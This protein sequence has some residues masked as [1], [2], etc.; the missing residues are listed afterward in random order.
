MVESPAGQER[1]EVFRMTGCLPHPAGFRVAVL[2]LT[3]TAASGHAH[4][5]DLFHGIGS[6][7][8]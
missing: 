7:V 2:V 1:P 3:T 6:M 8:S 5:R 4:Y